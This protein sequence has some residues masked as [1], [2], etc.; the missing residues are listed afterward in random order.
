MMAYNFRDELPEVERTE[1]QDAPEDESNEPIG[2]KH[3][4]Y[5]GPEDGPFECGRCDHYSSINSNHGH[6]DHPEV[7]EDLGTPAKVAKMGCCTYF[8]PGESD[9]D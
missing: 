2:T 4:G 3:S 7:E 5:A 8:R 9:G 6:C 1:Q